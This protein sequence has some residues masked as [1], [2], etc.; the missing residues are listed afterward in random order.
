MAETGDMTMA[1]FR[2][3]ATTHASVYVGEYEA[4]TQDEAE[5]MAEP[6]VDFSLCHQCG[7]IDINDMWEFEI[8]EVEE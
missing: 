6:D 5:V 4:D 3:Y 7:N 2:V 8:D 1:K